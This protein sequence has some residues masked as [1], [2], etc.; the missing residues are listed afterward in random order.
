MGYG[1]IV[2]NAAG[3]LQLDGENTHWTSPYSGTLFGTV[4]SYNMGPPRTIIT[5]RDIF[6]YPLPY[7]IGIKLSTS[8]WRAV[9]GFQKI[10]FATLRLMLHSVAGASL[11]WPYLAV[12]NEAAVDEAGVFVVMSGGAETVPIF[13][14][15]QNYVAM[16]GFYEINNPIT[17]TGSGNIG[18]AVNVTVKNAD[19]NFFAL[20]GF[21]WS[22]YQNSD[23][24]YIKTHQTLMRKVNSTTVQIGAPECRSDYNDQ[25][26]EP[27]WADY[28]NKLQIIEMNAPEHH[29]DD[30]PDPE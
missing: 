7:T 15:E 22:K 17:G 9:T 21:G 4:P 30:P 16:K 13:N 3:E 2:K 23:P 27:S 25:G 20:K 12:F 26:T 28:T 10:G 5:W 8:Q 6:E 11:S 14:S 1:I 24:G 18:S 19:E 29:E